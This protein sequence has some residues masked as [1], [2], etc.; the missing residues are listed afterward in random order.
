M[1]TECTGVDG[2]QNGGDGVCVSE[3]MCSIGYHNESGDGSCVLEGTCALGY[4]DGGDG[5]C[6]DEGACSQNY[7][8]GGDEN[9][10]TIGACSS[11]YEDDGNG[12]CVE[13][14]LCSEGYHNGGDDSCVA[15][16]TCSTGYHD[17]GDGECVLAGECADAYVLNDAGMCLIDYTCPAD[18][19]YEA[20]DDLQSLR[21]IELDEKIFGIVCTGNGDYYEVS[22]GDGCTIHVDLKFNH[23][24]GDLDI[25]LYVFETRTCKRVA[26]PFSLLAAEPASVKS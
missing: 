3:G 4:H 19:P 20:N 23:G 2:Y 1:V 22:N 25:E 13:I 6:V 26:D 15:E 16:G 18:D 10:V 5:S 11:G 21:S 8:D 9:C 14:N 24:E 7:H 17:D 12:S